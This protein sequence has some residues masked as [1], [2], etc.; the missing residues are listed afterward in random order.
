[1]PPDLGGIVGNSSSSSKL[2]ESFILQSALRE[3]V[4]APGVQDQGHIKP[5]HR[6]VAIRLV[7]EGGFDPS[8]ITPRPPLRSEK[9]KGR[10]FIVFDATQQSNSEST[11]V[12]GIKSKNVDVVVNKNGIGP[13]VAVS[14]KGTGNAFRNLTNRMEEIIGDCAN[15][16]MMYPG[17]VYG[18][19]HLIKANRAGQ[20]NISAN[21]VCID[22]NG[23][24]VNSI[25]RWHTVLSELT[26]R[27]MLA[28]DGMRYE[29]VSLLLA[30]TD[31][32]EVGCICPMF[33]LPDSPLLLDP[34]FQR[35]Y[36]LYDLRFSYKLQKSVIAR[37]V[38]WDES[39][40]AFSD[41][42]ELGPDWSA[43]LSYLPRTSS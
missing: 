33:P 6:Y 41:L 28:D 31:E 26:G 11:V 23:N 24:I 10:N 30:S 12:G 21:D 40:P 39:S 2:L 16:H 19:I 4:V 42:R 29:A 37:R 17:L 14:V 15:L 1:M 25:T 38:E 8:E 20:P 36:S 13:V 18:F 7:L 3:F 9:R 35:L 43:M 22:P 5:M 32:P 27:T 34:F